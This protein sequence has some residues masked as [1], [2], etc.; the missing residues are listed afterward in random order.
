LDNKRSGRQNIAWLGITPKN[1]TMAWEMALQ[2][3]HIIVGKVR[4]DVLIKF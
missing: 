4:N 3:R 1:I 2:L